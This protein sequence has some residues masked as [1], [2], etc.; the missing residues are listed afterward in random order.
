M[1]RNAVMGGVVGYV[2]GVM[3]ELTQQAPSAIRE[4]GEGAVHRARVATRRLGA[5]LDVISPMVGREDLR[6]I[7]R[8]LKKIRQSV[9]D[10][11]DLD[12]MQ[13]HL[14]DREKRGVYPEICRRFRQAMEERRQ[15][16]FTEVREEARVER[17][18][19]RV[20]H[21]MAL[22][23]G[24]IGREAEVAELVRSALREQFAAFAQ[25]ARRLSDGMWA[26]EHPEPAK[27]EITQEENVAQIANGEQIPS[28][29]GT[30][31]EAPPIE[32]HALRIAGKG[33]RYTFE[34]AQAQGLAVR[35][36]TLTAFKRMQDALGLWHDYHVLSQEMMQCA[37]AEM[38]RPS[39]RYDEDVVMLLTSR[40]IRESHQELHRFARLWRVRH[41]GLE[42][43]VT[44]VV[45]QVQA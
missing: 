35:A 19:S 42:T 14:D 6:L 31:E 2:D 20:G 4:G 26:K 43:Q 17:W 13:G 37:L 18:L 21:W 9:A 36:G 8:S 28:T 23:G 25:Q 3:A 44:S 16:L 30:K 33:L 39:Y 29:P 45:G 38:R 34:M 22:R 10:L 40:T 24:L 7:R 11:R 12:V 5:A 15:Q 1:A 32:P 27:T 41:E